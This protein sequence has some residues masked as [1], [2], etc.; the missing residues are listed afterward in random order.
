MKPNQIE[1]FKKSYRGLISKDTQNLRQMTEKE[2]TLF[3]TMLLAKKN[4]TEGRVNEALASQIEDHPFVKILSSRLGAVG[5]KLDPKLIF[6]IT[7]LCDRPGAVVMWAFTIAKITQELGKVPEF[8]EVFGFD[9]F[10]M[11]LPTPKMLEDAWRDQKADGE[12]E[13][14]NL[15]DVMDLWPRFPAL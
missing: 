5:I 2:T 15:L 1:E 11:G 3:V 14:D 7:Y 13:T 10:G 9:Y 8:E 6:F 12:S 4:G